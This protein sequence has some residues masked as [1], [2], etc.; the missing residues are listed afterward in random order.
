MKQLQTAVEANILRSQEDDVEEWYSVVL[1][2]NSPQKAN[3]NV[4]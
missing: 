4:L 3:T 1:S 2:P